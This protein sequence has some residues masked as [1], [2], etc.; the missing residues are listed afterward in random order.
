MDFEFELRWKAVIKEL[1]LKFGEEI[2]LEAILFL[3]GV[4]ELGLGARR[5]KKDEKVNLIHIGIC[6]VLEPLGYYQ[7][8][9][10]DEEGWPHYEMVQKI[11]YLSDKEQKE[12]MRHA[13]VEYFEGQGLIRERKSSD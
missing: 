10:R 13:V 6:A 8:S 11:P 3:I 12:L 1:E 7:Y 2:D 9:H 4:Q 5:F